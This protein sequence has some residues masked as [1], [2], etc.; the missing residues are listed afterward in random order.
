MTNNLL[1]LKK[2]LKSF[3]KKCKDFKYTDSALLTFLLN[4]MLISTGEM[5]AETVTKSQIN[6]QVSQ[7]N[8]SI[9]QM[10]TDFKRA[11]AEN[12][13]LIKDTNLELTQLME[14]GD[15]VTKSPWSS[16]QF[17]I[18]DFY[19]DWHGTY[20][21]RGDKESKYPY[22]GIFERSTN[23]YERSI[24]PDSSQYRLLSKNRKSNFASGSSNGFG[25]ASFKRVKEPIIPFEVNASINPRKVLKEKISITAPTFTTPTAPETISFVP[26]DPQI[27]INTLT[28]VVPDPISAPATGNGNE[29]YI[30]KT[31]LSNTLL[32]STRYPDHFPGGTRYSP[33]DR[34]GNRAY[35]AI[36]SQAD[37]SGSTIT[38][39]TTTKNVNINSGIIQGDVWNYSPLNYNISNYDGYEIIK[40]T[41]PYT[42]NITNSTITYD[43]DSSA[44]KYQRW[45]F[46]TDAHN[47]T[48]ASIWN[49][50]S[51]TTITVPNSGKYL[52][53]YTSQFH[54]GSKNAVFNNVDGIIEDKGENNIIWVSLSEN[55]RVHHKD[56]VFSNSG[57]IK[58]N[59][60][61]GIFAYID[62]PTTIG[63]DGTGAYTWSGKGAQTSSGNGDSGTTSNG[64]KITNSGT[65]N[66]G[67]SNNTGIFVNN[68]W[69]YH[70][71]E[72][73]LT[74]PMTISG[75][76]N[77]RV[78][79]IL[80][81]L[82]I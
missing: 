56:S 6:N 82:K 81:K 27:N 52:A 28:P 7:I 61:N 29:S 55:A 43:G 46:H 45:L 74:T 18:N 63:T 25:I 65:L 71:T 39:N 19:N 58:L 11:R 78:Y 21:G 76:E 9:N 67:G 37:I 42:L 69:K 80:C 66:L 30:L 60:K 40:N 10:R 77:T 14:Q 16:W 53:V 75:D 3:A 15:H 49:I 33:N 68:N 79:R 2:D 32:G 59:G 47:D 20:K 54:N 1:N 48:Q 5:F 22:S 34:V 44:N 31:D 35:N 50:N 23:V 13:K 72:I 51:G 41:G 62:T 24:S 64:W 70:T 36:I 12:N 26:A 8:T 4:G 38:Y 57:T 73:N 17:G